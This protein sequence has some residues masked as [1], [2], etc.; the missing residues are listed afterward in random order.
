MDNEWEYSK[1]DI[2]KIGVNRQRHVR[3]AGEN[4]M[5]RL[6]NLTAYIAPK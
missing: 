1:S 2:G 6:I 4:T 3:S 5:I